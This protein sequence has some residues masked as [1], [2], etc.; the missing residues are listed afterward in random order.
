[1]NKIPE[2]IKAP[3][4]AEAFTVPVQNANLPAPKLAGAYFNAATLVFEKQ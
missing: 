3:D 1:M 4:P 2:H